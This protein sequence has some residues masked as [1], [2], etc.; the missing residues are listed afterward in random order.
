MW[1]RESIWSGAQVSQNPG[2]QVIPGPICECCPQLGQFQGA[3]LLNVKYI[4]I[5]YIIFN[6]I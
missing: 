6:I 4:Y 3:S 2:V 1:V 5:Y